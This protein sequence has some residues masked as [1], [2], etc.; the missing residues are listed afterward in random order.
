MSDRA[1]SARLLS[2]PHLVRHVIHENVMYP[3]HAPRTESPEYAAMHHQLVVVDDRPCAICGIRNSEL[4]DPA[5]NVLGVKEMETHHLWVE[6]ALINAT[7][8]EK[9]SEFFGEHDE[10]HSFLDHDPANLL[11]LCDIHHR[12][13]EAGIHELSFPIWVAQKFARSDYPLLTPPPAAQAP[14]GA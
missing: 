11:V 7:D 9:L 6:W 13:H 12:H 3:P 4:D 1:K 10:W 5:K 8:P 14:S 2:K